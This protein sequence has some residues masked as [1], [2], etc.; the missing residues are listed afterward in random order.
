MNCKL[1]SWENMSNG[2]N[3]REFL[4]TKA[5]QILEQPK[6]TC[7]RW[8]C[9]DNNSKCKLFITIIIRQRQQQWKNECY[10]SKLFPGRSSLLVPRQMRICQSE[11]NSSYRNLWCWVEREVRVLKKR[12]HM[13]HFLYLFIYSYFHRLSCTLFQLFTFLISLTLLITMSQSSFCL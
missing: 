5:A 8:E 4:I 1:H 3:G 9:C 13:L 12:R 7:A 11:D 6:L 2:R 10:S